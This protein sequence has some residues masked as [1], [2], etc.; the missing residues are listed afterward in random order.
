MRICT[1]KNFV[2]TKTRFNKML[3]LTQKITCE[4]NYIKNFP[5]ASPRTPFKR[6]GR[7]GRERK[8]KIGEGRK[9][10]DGRV[11]ERSIPK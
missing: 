1:S 6:Q 8:G 4:H 5:G 7:V 3:N 10:G 2:W 11:R 9:R